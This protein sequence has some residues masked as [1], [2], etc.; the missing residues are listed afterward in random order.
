MKLWYRCSFCSPDQSRE[1]EVLELDGANLLTGAEV[2]ADAYKLVSEQH[3]A[4]SPKCPA[5][6]SC[7]MV[8]FT[9]RPVQ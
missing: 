9:V 8:E 7:H 1:F 6:G 5:S 4:D 2:I 3:R